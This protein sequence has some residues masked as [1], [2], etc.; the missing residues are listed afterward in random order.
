MSREIEKI[1]V[2]IDEIAS[3]TNLLALNASIEAARAGEM[4]RGFA[5]VATEVG[6]L[7]ARSSEAARETNELIT[8][9]L[10]AISEGMKLTQDT[11]ATF[12][13]VVEEIECA[14]SEVE[15]IADMV[16]KNVTVVG[17]A[18]VEINKITNV[19]NANAEISENSRKISANMANITDS[20]LN[21]VGQ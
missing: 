1:I 2:E 13:K 17:Q 18:A 5:V 9:S 21:I 16:R 7:A 8:N 4:G 15:Q 12:D 19:L 11:A 20:L 14:N 6:N 3:Q 10:H